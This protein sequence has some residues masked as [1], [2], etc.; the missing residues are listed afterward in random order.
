M[1]IEENKVTLKNIH[2]PNND[3][4]DFY[5][6]VREFLLDFDNEYFFLCGDFNLALNPLQDTINYC[7]MNNPKARSKVLEIMEDLNLL[8][9][10]R[11]YNPDK[12]VYTLHKKILSS[13]V[14]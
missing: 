6:S 9:Y 1:T 2:S 12:R 3:N 8:D 5:D 10:Y 7:G 13:K 11:V 4:P 14:V